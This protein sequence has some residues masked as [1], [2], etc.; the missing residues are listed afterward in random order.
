MSNSV[1][2]SVVLSVVLCMLSADSGA[3]DSTPGEIFGALA[4]HLVKEQVRSGE[5][6]GAWPGEQT[7]TGS[8]VAGLASVYQATCVEDYRI[9]AEAG[10]EFFLSSAEGNYFGDE[11]YALVLLDRISGAPPGNQWGAA[12]RGF[13][14]DVKE[15]ATGSTG[16][17][18]AQFDQ[19]E[20]SVAVFYLAHHVVACFAV[21]AEDADIWRMALKKYLSRVDDRSASCPVMALGIATWALSATEPLD[22]SPLAESPGS[23]DYWHGKRLADLPYLLEDHQVPPGEDFAGSFY[24]RFDHSDGETGGPVSGYTE[25]LVFGTLGLVAAKRSDPQLA[26]DAAISNA[27]KTLLSG[28]QG[29]DLARQHLWFTSESYHFYTAEVLRALCQLRQIGDIDLD[30]VVDCVDFSGLADRWKESA[31]SQCCSCGG[32]D[33]DRDGQV[34]FQDLMLLA[35]G[36]LE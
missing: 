23:A 17:Y 6:R 15:R 34:D 13:Y 12:V 10:G 32:A 21:G 11:A 28:L 29:Q 3:L 18:V 25:D 22:D 5:L 14:A 24:W 7:F 2:G 27:H 30:D 9:A 36:W 31:C 4:D 8:I 35:E 1:K 26:V 20:P 19:A 33:L 16:G